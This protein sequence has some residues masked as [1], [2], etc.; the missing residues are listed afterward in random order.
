MPETPTIDITGEPVVS[1]RHFPPQVI[2]ERQ[3]PGVLDS[4]ETGFDI[5]AVFQNEETW[6]I[7][8]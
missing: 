3:D 7:V 1:T 6:F 4:A 5:L 2:G 8:D